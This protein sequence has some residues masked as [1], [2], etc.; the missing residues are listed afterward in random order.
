LQRKWN[1]NAQA[2]V[3]GLG[4]GIPNN[5]SSDPA[6]WYFATAEYNAGAGGAISMWPGSLGFAA[7]TFD[8]K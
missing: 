4:L 3:E 1:N 2:F 7:A 8:P 5:N 6:P